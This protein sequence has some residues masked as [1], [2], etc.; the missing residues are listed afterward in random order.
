MAVLFTLMVTM[1]IIPISVNGWGLRELAVT[2]FLNAHGM[3]TQRALLFSVC[4]GLTL[5][6]AA[7]PGA[8]IMLV[9]SPRRLRRPA[10]PTV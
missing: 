4:Y 10:T 7:L 2:A 6:V 9:Y 3:P 8:A 1:A 5:V